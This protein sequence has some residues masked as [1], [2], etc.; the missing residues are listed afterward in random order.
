MEGKLFKYF[1]ILMIYTAKLFFKDKVIS[2]AQK[3]FF[4]ALN[5]ASSF[6]QLLV[7]MMLCVSFRGGREKIMLQ[8]EFVF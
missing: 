5:T 6:F 2:N 1:L 7:E 3:S 4:I 8:N